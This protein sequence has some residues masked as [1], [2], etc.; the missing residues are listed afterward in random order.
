[1]QNHRYC[2]KFVFGKSQLRSAAP[3][4]VYFVQ[5]AVTAK[6]D[7][8]KMTMAILFI[9]RYAVELTVVFGQKRLHSN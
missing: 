1:M 8:R 9:K 5:A 7:R 2:G 3:S 4:G 6:E